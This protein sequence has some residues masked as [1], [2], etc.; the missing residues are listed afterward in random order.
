ML[1]PL[2]S[3]WRWFVDGLTETLV[4]AQ[5]RLNPRPIFRVV[6]DEHD[7]CIRAES[8][9]ALG[10]L[11]G[12]GPDAPLDPPEL[13]ARLEGAA[14]DVEIPSAWALRRALNPIAAQSAP[15]AEAFAR[16]QIE[17]ITPWRSS[18]AYFRVTTKP[19][20]G[21]PTRLSVEVDVVARRMVDAALGALARLR[22]SRL[23]LLTRRAED[24]EPI[25]IPTHSLAAPREQQRRALVQTVLIAVPLVFVAWF[26]FTFVRIGALSDEAADLDRRIEARRAA[27][28]SAS[29]GEGSGADP[30]EELRVR[31]SA[32][33][34]VV[35]TMEALSA[36]LPEHAYLTDFTLE[37]DK[38]RISGVAGKASDLVPSLEQSHRFA[39]VTFNAATTREDNGATDRFHLEMRIVGAEPAEP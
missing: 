35:E 29:G 4:A 37:N 28:F 2:K 14:I 33:P 20:P 13:A 16:H 8:G 6:L 30:A 18:D 32:H 27:L 24:Q 34:R 31:R 19:L 5:E 10:A 12:A 26:I 23:R 36:A 7:A 1:G 15:F 17:R 22:P 39:D 9:A 21:D 25:T 38:L 11:V 3:F